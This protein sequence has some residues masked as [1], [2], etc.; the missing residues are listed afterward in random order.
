MKDSLGI[1]FSGICVVHCLLFSLFVWGGVGSVGFIALSE[2]FI[3]PLL[4]LIV[5]IIGLISFPSSYKI[6][7]Q[8]QPMAIGALGFIGLLVALMMPLVY[9]ILLTI[10]SGTMLIMSHLWNYRLTN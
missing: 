2:E 7:K 3:H 4:V 8:V 1:L 6:H 10:I 9:E 5:F